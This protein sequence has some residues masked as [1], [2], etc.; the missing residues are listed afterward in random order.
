MIIEIVIFIVIGLI[1]GV[2]GGMGMGGG[3][4]LI[5][6]LTLF[7]GVEQHLAQSINLLAFIPT[8]IVAL[9]IHF[10]NKLVEKK[11]I[12][13]VAIPAVIVS[14]LASLLSKAVNGKS[15][16][17]YFGIFLAVLGLYQLVCAVISVV[18][19]YKDKKKEK[20]EE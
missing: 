11:H 6:L 4:L 7:G 8:A 2:I 1:G 13:I 18:K 14:V 5:P 10:R 15:L 17:V 3:T 12:I 19:N 9:I 16:S 20:K